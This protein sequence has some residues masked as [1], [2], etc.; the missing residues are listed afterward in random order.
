LISP[1][2]FTNR[3]SVILIVTVTLTV[4][5]ILTLQVKE[6]NY[7]MTSWWSDCVYWDT[8]IHDWST[9]GCRVTSDTTLAMTHCSCSHMT[10]FATR[11][12]VVRVK[13]TK[14]KVEDYFK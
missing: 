9:Q 10:A 8:L 6:R 2:T 5:V 1:T 14:E 12:E 13:V 7:T 3:T 4:I 11:Q